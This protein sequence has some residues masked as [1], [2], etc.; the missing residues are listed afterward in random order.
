MTWWIWILAGLVLLGAEIAVPGGIIL[1]FFGVAA[2]VVGALVA[3]GL[4]GPV[5]WQW[6]LFSI[7]SVVSLVTLRGPI[8]KRLGRRSRRG[9]SVDS[10]VGQEVA[11][12]ADLAPGAEGKVELRGTSWTAKNVGTTPVGRG[13]PCRV[14][15]VE[16]LKLFVRA[17]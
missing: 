9:G 7:L 11:P 10:L 13:Q 1:L 2:L 15:R 6:L 8:L 14:E 17:S 3:T 4:G 16:G 12:L 5:W